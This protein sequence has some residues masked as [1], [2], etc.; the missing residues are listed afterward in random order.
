VLW[1]SWNF[2]IEAPGTGRH[3]KPGY[4]ANN[5]PY[6]R[7]HPSLGVHHQT[8]RRAYHPPA[9]DSCRKITH[10]QACHLT[11]ISSADVQQ[12]VCIRPELSRMGVGT[13]GQPLVTLRRIAPPLAKNFRVPQ[14]GPLPGFV[15]QRQQLNLGTWVG[16]QHH[17]SFHRSWWHSPA[18]RL[19]GFQQLHYFHP[20]DSLLRGVKLCHPGRHV[21][22]PLQTRSVNGW[23]TKRSHGHRG[24]DF[25]TWS[26]PCHVV[27][28][29]RIIPLRGHNYPYPTRP[30][31]SRTLQGVSET[32]RHA[33]GSTSAFV[34]VSCGYASAFASFNS[35]WWLHGY[36]TRSYGGMPFDFRWSVPAYAWSPAPT[37]GCRPLISARFPC[38]T[39]KT[40]RGMEMGGGRERDT[41]GQKIKTVFNLKMNTLIMTRK[42]W[43][44]RAL[45]S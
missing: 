5:A 39:E 6:I 4:G 20:C 12:L 36:I 43:K 8:G 37:P 2:K 3:F 22:E 7:G 21:L 32:I 24:G 33:T 28:V 38:L 19:P 29:Q 10:G 34:R 31:T 13:V 14:N 27:M 35:H 17:Y 42:I 40:E 23:R 18:W 44:I 9:K 45:F 15:H 1:N 41:H 16:W 25:F 26:L 30:S 11:A